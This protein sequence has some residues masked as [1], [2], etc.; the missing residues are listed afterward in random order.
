MTLEISEIAIRMRV[1]E[2][3]GPREERGGDAVRE[4]GCH[5]VERAALVDDCVRRVLQVLRTLD[6]R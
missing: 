3:D 2:S 6:Q 1:A 4:G 5:D